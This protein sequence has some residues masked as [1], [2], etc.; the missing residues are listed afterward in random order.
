MAALG[1]LLKYDTGLRKNNV[2]K[3]RMA[4]TTRTPDGQNDFVPRSE[5]RLMA[6]GCLLHR[7]IVL[8][9]RKEF[10]PDRTTPGPDPYA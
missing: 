1:T 7:T 2:A 8:L 6:D 9:L 5:L 3:L 10:S 4:A